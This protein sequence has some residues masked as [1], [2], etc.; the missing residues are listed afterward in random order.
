[1]AIVSSHNICRDVIPATPSNPAPCCMVRI[2]I[3][4]GR[5]CCQDWKIDKAVN[6]CVEW[7]TFLYHC[8]SSLRYCWTY[9]EHSSQCVGL[10]MHDV[11]RTITIM[12]HD[13]DVLFKVF[14]I[15]TYEKNTCQIILRS[16]HRRFSSQEKAIWLE[17]RRAPPTALNPAFSVSA[18]RIQNRIYLANMTGGKPVWALLG[19]LA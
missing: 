18:V 16:Q 14:K 3:Q 6:P 13:T 17:M 11:G 10:N 5:S 2:K 15:S 12:T 8:P 4:T 19:I 1:M 9:Q 7:K